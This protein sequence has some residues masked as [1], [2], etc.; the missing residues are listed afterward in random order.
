MFPGSK[1][2]SQTD[3]DLKLDV[4]VSSEAKTTTTVNDYWLSGIKKEIPRGIL[5]ENHTLR[6]L[7]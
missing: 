2:P 1:T 5:Q 3:S 7:A 4:G 6:V